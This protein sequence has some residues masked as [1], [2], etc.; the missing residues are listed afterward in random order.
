MYIYIYL[1]NESKK[2]KWQ[3]LSKNTCTRDL[4][5][6]AELQHRHLGSVVPKVKAEV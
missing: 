4:T 1:K 5:E 3:R 2:R 6:I